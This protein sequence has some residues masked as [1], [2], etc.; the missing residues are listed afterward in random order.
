[1][2]KIVWA[3]FSVPGCEA[4]VMEEEVELLSESFPWWNFRDLILVMLA[5]LAMCQ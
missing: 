1:M 2:K 3:P 4:Q 5:G